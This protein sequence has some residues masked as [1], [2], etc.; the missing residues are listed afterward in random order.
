MGL[1]F[2]SVAVVVVAELHLG[3]SILVPITLAIRSRSH[4][5]EPEATHDAT[6]LYFEDVRARRVADRRETRRS[7]RPRTTRTSR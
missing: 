6:E 1:L 7:H 2:I 4:A 5:D 3:R